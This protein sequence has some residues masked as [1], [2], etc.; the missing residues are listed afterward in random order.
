MGRKKDAQIANLEE[1]NKI[2]A[3]AI[4][5]HREDFERFVEASK[6]DWQDLRN[7][8]TQMIEGR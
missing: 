1:S 4:R 8:L 2:L 3:K 6:K 5:I 7:F